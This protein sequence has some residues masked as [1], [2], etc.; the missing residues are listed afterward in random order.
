[1]FRIVFG[2]MSLALY[3][4]LPMHAGAAALPNQPAVGLEQEDG[5]RTLKNW[6]AAPFVTPGMSERL[7]PD[8][9]AFTG[10][11]AWLIKVAGDDLKLAG[12]KAFSLAGMDNPNMLAAAPLNQEAVAVLDSHPQAAGLSIMFNGE[13]DGKPARGIALILRGKAESG[14]FSNGVHAFMA[15]ETI[16]VALG[17][18]AIP[19][20]KY[21]HANE[22]RT[23]PQTKPDPNW[24]MREDGSL[25]PLQAV[26]KLSQIFT[27]WVS[28]YVIP[29]TM[30]SANIQTQTLQNMRSWNNASNACAGDPNCSV[31]PST[32]GSGGWEAS[33]D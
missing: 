26:N 16:F 30:M 22:L 21:L 14:Q 33:F 4:T 15:P 3:L 7:I 10:A 13:L 31:T 2:I 1:M 20:V 24:K 8:H 27:D 19:A 12:R 17:G 18:Y 11:E 9:P 5:S 32:D 6:S 28:D 25:P 23:K 29:M